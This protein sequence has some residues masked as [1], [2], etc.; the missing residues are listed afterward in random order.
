MAHLVILITSGVILPCPHHPVETAG[1]DPRCIGES[2]QHE[3]TY[4]CMV[5]RAHVGRGRGD[6]GNLFTDAQPKTG[7]VHDFE[8][9]REVAK[10]DMDT[11]KTD[12]RKVAEL[13]VQRFRPVVPDDFPMS[14]VKTVSISRVDGRLTRSLRRSSPLHEP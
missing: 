6:E 13:A 1:K 12:E 9:Q 7:T 3:I 8:S 2:S 10:K 4:P 14:S 11:K 5:C